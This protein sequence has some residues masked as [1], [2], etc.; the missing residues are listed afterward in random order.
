MRPATLDEYEGQSHILAPGKLLRR[1][2][3]SDRLFSVILYG[4]PG[5]GKTSLG[6]VVAGVTRSALLMLNAVEA[7]VGDLRAAVARARATTDRRTILFIDEVHRFNK[8]QQ[9]V[10]LAPL[11]D[12]VVTMIGATV[13][14]P[15]FYLNHALLSR[16]QV[17][18]LRPLGEGEI[19]DI[20]DRA[21]SDRDSGLGDY[22]VE[23]TPEAR[24]HL[25]ENCLGDARKALSALELAVLST[26]PDMSGLIRVGLDAAAECLTKRVV[27]YDRDGDS[28]YDV[29]SAFIKSVR[30]SQPDAALA[31]MARMLSGGEDPRFVARRLVISASED[32]GMADPRALLVAVAAARAVEMV[33][34]PEARYALAEAAIYLATAPKSRSCADAVGEALED[35]E[36]GAAPEVPDDLRDASYAGAARLRHGRG[37]EMPRSESEGRRGDYGAGEAVYYRPGAS[38]FEREV[39]ERLSDWDDAPPGAGSEVE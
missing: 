25:V 9:D 17:F 3:E 37:Y 16:V 13:E 5:S 19:S 7:G 24:A 38:G 2:V 23:L 11:E 18:E 20:L 31:W 28:H 4:P 26:P 36:N 1:A 29:A 39:R 8:A 10:L 6:H 34:M 21:L 32:I 30:A 33:G 14:N 35:V 22:K 15:F 27:R 12:D